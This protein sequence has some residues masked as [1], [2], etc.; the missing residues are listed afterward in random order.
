MKINEIA[1]AISGKI[2]SQNNNSDTDILFAYTS[3]LLSMVLKNAVSDMA[4]ITIQSNINAVAVCVLM[5]SPLLIL[6]EGVKAD[7]NAL[8]KANEENV[9][10]I[11]SPLSAYA[12][13]GIL[14]SN[15]ILPAGME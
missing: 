13:S 7:S 11:E 2:I 10:I 15:N 3:D 6:A 5:E 12:I 4:L 14:Y 9:C 8:D 1:T